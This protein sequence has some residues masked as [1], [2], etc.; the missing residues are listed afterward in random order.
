MIGSRLV[1]IN[2]LQQ[3]DILQAGYKHK[4]PRNIQNLPKAYTEI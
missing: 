1:F 4:T 3:L 2:I